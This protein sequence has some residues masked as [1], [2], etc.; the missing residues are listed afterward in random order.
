MRG[1]VT[2]DNMDG[3]RSASEP[4]FVL[5]CLA[6]THELRADYNPVVGKPGSVRKLARH[7]Q[8]FRLAGGHKRRLVCGKDEFNYAAIYREHALP[9]CRATDCEDAVGGGSAIPKYSSI[10]EIDV[11]GF[12]QFEIQRKQHGAATVFGKRKEPSGR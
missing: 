11:T 6:L 10:R 1:A 9:P 7:G 3:R 5:P 2:F 4:T 8:D 12:V